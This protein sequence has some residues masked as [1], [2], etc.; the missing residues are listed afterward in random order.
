MNQVHE[1]FQ[2]YGQRNNKYNWNDKG[3]T[4]QGNLVDGVPNGF[5]I[6]YDNQTNKDL[7]NG[8]WKDGKRHGKGTEFVP[9]SKI[10]Y[11]GDF[12]NDRW[13]GKGK[14]RHSDSKALM[15]D[16]DFQYD[17]YHGQ[18]VQYGMNY[19]YVGNFE[20]NKSFGK[21]RVYNIITGVMVY[22]G[23]VDSG[24]YHGYGIKYSL[25]HSR[26]YQ[27]KFRNGVLC[28]QAT[29]KDLDTGSV[30]YT[31]EVDYCKL[32]GRGTYYLKNG[33][34]LVGNFINDDIN[35]NEKYKIYK[36]NDGV[37]S[38]IYEGL[39]KQDNKD[40]VNDYNEF[41]SI[42]LN[43]STKTIEV[44]IDGT[45]MEVNS[46]DQPIATRLRKRKCEVNAPKAMKKP[47]VIHE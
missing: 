36:S 47:N 11:T 16:G 10:T 4:Y 27:G 19:K 26:S 38:C 7:Y 5:G 13:H 25:A 18:G 42:K 17:V 40:W 23:E 32:H 2:L 30:I 31:G 43:L 22:E 46:D 44:Q 33:Y 15:Y 1:Y 24:Y 6:L 45:S 8:Y 29:I 37:V 34:T 21:C 28:G 20:N 41:I 35:I 3:L 39:L 9:T 12:V 14:M